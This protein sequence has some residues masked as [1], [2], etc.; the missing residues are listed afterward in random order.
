MFSEGAGIVN[1]GITT[2]APQIPSRIPPYILDVN[3]RY[4]KIEDINIK[5]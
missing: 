2:I 1:A 5:A 4:P 3:G